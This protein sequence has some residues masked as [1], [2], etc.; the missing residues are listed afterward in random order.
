[1]R[2]GRPGRLATALLE[3]EIEPLEGVVVSASPDYLKQL[4]LILL[5]NA[6][7]YTPSGGHVKV[8][9]NLNEGEAAITVTDTGIGIAKAD[10]PRIFDRSFRAENAHFRSGVGLGLAIARRIIDQH[11]GKIEVATEL[12]QGSAF[13]VSLPLMNS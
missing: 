10:V 2:A 6:V 7:K 3:C 5:D 9:G 12:G 4:F 11:G 13:T 8:T 1:M